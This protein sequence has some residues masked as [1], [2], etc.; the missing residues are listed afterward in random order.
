MSDNTTMRDI[1]SAHRAEMNELQSKLTAAESARDRMEGSL[2]FE[3]RQVE[4]FER[5]VEKLESDNRLERDRAAER[6]K[7][8]DSARKQVEKLRDAL[9][10]LKIELANEREAHTKLRDATAKK[11]AATWSRATARKVGGK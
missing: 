5:R 2:S 1:L 9:E 7:E 11:R 6:A 8:R 4:M 3:S 10:S